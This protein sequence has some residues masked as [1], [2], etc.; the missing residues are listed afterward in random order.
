MTDE[1]IFQI[2]HQPA[3]LWEPWE[4][5]KV[6][7]SSVK[8]DFC[9]Y[10][11]V[12]KLLRSPP[13]IDRQSRSSADAPVSWALTLDWPRCQRNKKS[14]SEA[15]APHAADNQAVA[16]RWMRFVSRSDSP[17]KS[18]AKGNR[19][20]RWLEFSVFFFLPLVCQ[21]RGWDPDVSL[22]KW[23][24]RF[25]RQLPPV[26]VLPALLLNNHF[27]ELILNSS[28]GSASL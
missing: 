10:L 5:T 22:C 14:Q 3:A 12:A 4:P 17:S 21:A 23:T 7:I 9:C 16:G 15:S 18:A 24:S 13:L 25:Q 19:R 26:W 6:R 1:E 8:T 2:E 28:S 27:L 20:R 11:E